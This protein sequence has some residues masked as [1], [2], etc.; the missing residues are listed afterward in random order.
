[1]ERTLTRKKEALLIAKGLIESILES[2]DILDTVA[3]DFTPKEL[4]IIWMRKV[5][6]QTLEETGKVFGFTRERVR[7]IEEEINKKL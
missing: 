2:D 1:M 4:R 5:K 3:L 6:R 7:Q